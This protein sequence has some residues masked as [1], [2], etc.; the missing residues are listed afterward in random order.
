M[1]VLKTIT[2]HGGIAKTPIEILER[3]RELLSDEAHWIQG[4]M[5][6]PMSPVDPSE[7][8]Q[9]EGAYE[10]V[11]D[12]LL[13]DGLCGGG[14]G[15]CA[16]GAV[17]LMTGLNA[18]VEVMAVKYNP[19]TCEFDDIPVKSMQ[20]LVS[21]MGTPITPD[22]G[23]GATKTRVKRYTAAVEALNAAA[24]QRATE[25]AFEHP[26]VNTDDMNV[27]AVNDADGDMTF[28]D[29]VTPHSAVIDIFELAIRNL[30]AAK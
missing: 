11:A 2:P 28:K 23:K 7:I 5:F 10:R 30:E 8:D 12:E 18:V 27:W 17:S 24:K 26:Y 16:V 29:G 9:A 3:S 15:V 19:T 20:A 1:K 14:W 13:R 22:E 4:G 6:C 25:G 21:E